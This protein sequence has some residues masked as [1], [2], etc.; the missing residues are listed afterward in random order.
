MNNEIREKQ[1]K[2][3]SCEA[4]TQLKHK[5]FFIKENETLYCGWN[6]GFFSNCSVTFWSLI[7]LFNQGIV[8][9]KIDFSRSFLSYKTPAQQQGQIDLYPFYF[10]TDIAKEIRIDKI[11][12]KPYQHGIY[13]NL[14]FNSYNLFMEKYWNL[15]DSILEIQNM[16]IEKYK[17]DFS[18]TLAVIYR[19]TD[20]DKEVKLADPKLYLRKAEEILNQNTDFRILI[21]TDQKQ[22]RD[23]FINHFNDRCFFLEEMPVNDGEKALHNL[24]EKILKTNKCEFGK[25][26][27]A[28]T[29]LISKCNF[30]VNHTGNMALWICLF[31]GNSDNMFQFDREGNLVTSWYLI[32]ERLNRNWYSIKYQLKQKIKWVLSS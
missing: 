23:L 15:S 14:D 5:N 10:R 24:D 13:K 20:K 9:K 7:E 27:L 16:L 4:I 17:I 22:V 11:I 25:M 32:K 28:V 3:N 31:R 6:H 2:Q 29:H 12:S 21:Q 19:G 18:K 8:T 1:A 26:V 30:I